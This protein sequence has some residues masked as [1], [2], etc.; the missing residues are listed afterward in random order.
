MIKITIEE[1]GRTQ[2]YQSD[3]TIR[4]IEFWDGSAIGWGR[5]PEVT[6]KSFADMARA[7]GHTVTEVCVDG[8]MVDLTHVVKTDGAPM[9]AAALGEYFASGG[10]VNPGLTINIM[11]D[12]DDGIGCA[13]R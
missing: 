2:T 11:H 6:P 7:A 3:S 4:S 5:R 8:E 12:Y 13:R 9:D 10:V 1:N